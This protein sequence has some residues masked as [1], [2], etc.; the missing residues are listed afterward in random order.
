MAIKSTPTERHRHV[1]LAAG[2]VLQ[3]D[4]VWANGVDDTP[5]GSRLQF[6]VGS[7]VAVRVRRD[8]L[9]V[10]AYVLHWADQ[11]QLLLMIAFARK[12]F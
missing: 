12:L 4:L 2:E 5:P 7:T 3:Q 8:V 10:G 1:G 11:F 9:W 6:V